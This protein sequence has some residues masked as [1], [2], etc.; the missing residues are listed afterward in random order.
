MRAFKGILQWWGRCRRRHHISGVKQVGTMSE[1]PEALGALLVIVGPPHTPKWA[2][3]QCPCR[4]GNRID[5]N[6]SSARRPCWEVQV[7]DGRATLEPSL[8]R[9]KGTCESHFFVEDNKIIWV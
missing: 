5:V 3:L 9:P 4:C 8:R 2:L 1:A 7:R 6:L